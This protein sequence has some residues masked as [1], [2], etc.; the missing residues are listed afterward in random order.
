MGETS[1]VWS[2]TVFGEQKVVGGGD[3][4]LDDIIDWQ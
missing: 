4:F 1:I 2:E 3:S